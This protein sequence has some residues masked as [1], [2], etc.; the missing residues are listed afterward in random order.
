MPSIQFRPSASSV[1]CR[2]PEAMNSTR[3]LQEVWTGILGAKI[4]SFDTMDK[5]VVECK[6]HPLYASI[7][8][9]FN[10]HVPLILYPDAIWLQI[11]QQ[12]A[13]H[14]RENAEQLRSQIVDF[15]GKKVLRVRR[16]AFVKGKATNPWDKVFPE[17]AEQI[18]VFIGK[19]NYDSIVNTFSTTTPVTKAAQ[20]VALMDCV[21]SYF[22]LLFQT[23]C[24]IPFITLEGTRQ[25]WQ[26]LLD[27]TKALSKKFDLEWWTKELVPV[28]QEFVNVFDG[29]VNQEFWKNFVNV[30]ESSGGPYFTGHMT[31]LSAYKTVHKWDHMSKGPSKQAGYA[32]IEEWCSEQELSTGLTTKD[33]SSGLSMVPF[34][35]QYFEKFY[36]MN[37]SSGFVGI[38]IVDGGYR[39]N[40]SW[41][42]ADR[43]ASTATEFEEEVS[44]YAKE[45]QDQGGD[46]DID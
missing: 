9:S 6:F 39:P 12:V 35:W 17:F 37:F 19:D 28:L 3:P 8:K 4:E 25:D 34:V 16:D 23:L 14:I 33:F 18:K 11:L 43:I 20:E 38:E 45:L 21:Q 5:Q 13:I 31:K 10:D 2:A 40:I 29:T 7:I 36:P 30:E 44:R 26:V 27:K 1:D 22:D 41:A 15:D 42:I 24:G 46:S 32:R